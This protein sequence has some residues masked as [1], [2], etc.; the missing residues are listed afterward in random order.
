MI[1]TDTT[2]PAFNPDAV[3]LPWWRR[4]LA[5]GAGYILPSSLFVFVPMLFA[6]DYTPLTWTLMFLCAGAILVFYLGSPLVAHWPETRRWLW[7]LGLCLTIMSMG[8]I[9]PHSRFYYFAPFVTSISA[10]LITW[11]HARMVII[12]TS[13]MTVGLSVLRMDMFGVVMALMAITLG[14][15]LGSGLESERV[16][17]ALAL[18]EERTAVLAVAAERERIGRDLHDILGHSLTTIAVKADL[19]S[20]LVGRSDEDA[21]SEIEQVA[22]VARQ[23]LA[24]VRSTAS[25][26]HEVRLAS[27]IASARS[28]LQAA[29]IECRVPSALPVL[30]DV[31]S[32]A[33]GY[34]VREGVT[35]VVRH[36]G[37]ATC[38]IEVA[39]DCVAVIDDGHGFA[40]TKR[41]TGL[42]GL[43][44]RI[45]QA[46]GTLE[47]DSGSGGT[48]IRAVLHDNVEAGWAEVT[49]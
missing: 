47:V 17:R 13:S 16:K 34:V 10:Y 35:N 4:A 39:D 37:A 45:E 18:A 27:E 38:T 36:S 25:G 24:D 42:R 19:A 29:G 9:D 43:T 30:D 5:Q 28:V 44:E 2:A 48:T 6:Q 33:F 8:F 23:A 12:A 3:G 41:R 22:E 49:A 1:Q 31:R 20:R 14:W 21:R 46:G 40:R 32:E 26:M 11:R 15:G 7:L